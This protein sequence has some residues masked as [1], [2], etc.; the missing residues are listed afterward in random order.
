MMGV[1]AY[2][3]EKGLRVRVRG[4]C[5]G[6]CHLGDLCKSEVWSTVVPTE[7]IESLGFV[8]AVIEGLEN[9][10]QEYDRLIE[11]IDH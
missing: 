10:L 5:T 6:Q 7:R 4:V 2:V 11:L 3:V 9:V 8:L 1:E